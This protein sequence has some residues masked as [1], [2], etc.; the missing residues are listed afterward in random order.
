MK[1]TVGRRGVKGGKR[2]DA[3]QF[4]D[5]LSKGQQVTC[6]GVVRKFPDHDSH[7]EINT[8]NGSKEILV[9]VEL[10]PSQTRVLCRLGFGNDQ[11]FKIPRVDQEVA[12]LCPYDPQSLIKDPLDFEPIIV[13]V[14][15]VNVPSEIT[16]DGDH[17][18]KGSNKVTIDAP[19]VTCGAEAGSEK[20][21]KGDTFLSALNTLI[22]ALST[23]ATGIKSVADPSNSSTPA[24]LSAI[25]VFQTN[26]A[27]YK[28]T[29][30]KV[31]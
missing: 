21:L 18:I 15:D 22:T 4:R 24:L 8:E 13:G 30:A 14:L 16:G 31:T 11:H 23:Y 19:T 27:S 9:D 2:L 12:V 6:L 29:Q 5:L 10:I 28:A 1:T 3:N 20:A 7:F 25:G 17:I 26:L